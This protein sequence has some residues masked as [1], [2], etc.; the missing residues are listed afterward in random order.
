MAFVNTI[1][2]YLELKARGE[3][4]IQWSIS[5]HELSRF[6]LEERKKGFHRMLV[7]DF[8]VEAFNGSYRYR[9]TSILP[10]GKHR[11]NTVAAVYK[12]DPEYIEW[13]LMNA[14]AFCIAQEDISI[15][16]ATKVFIGDDLIIREIDIE[17]YEV[18]LTK[19]KVNEHGFPVNDDIA[20][21]EF[22]F[23]IAAQIQNEAK[24]LDSLN[25]FDVLKGGKW[26]LN[27]GALFKGKK[28]IRIIIKLKSVLL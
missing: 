3:K 7:E 24:L 25:A 21:I 27:N 13:C 26:K 10:F 11:G 8:R 16:N 1:E 22:S 15:L 19:F 2:E 17:T 9:L 28:S 20:N 4:S 5:N 14:S 23:T 18:D 6:I 12:C